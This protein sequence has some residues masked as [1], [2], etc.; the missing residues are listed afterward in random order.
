MTETLARLEGSPE[1]L[2]TRAPE[3]VLAE[4]QRAANALKNVISHKEKRVVINGEVY[5]EFE[6]WST[7]GSFYNVAAGAEDAIPVEIF[8]VKGA[9]ATAYVIRTDTGLR[10]SSAVAYC[11]ED[12]E[13]WQD[14]PWFQLA[15]MAQ[16]RAGAKALRFVLSK[17]V[18]LAGY[19]PTPAEEMEGVK[20]KKAVVF[21]F[22]KHKDQEPASLELKDLHSELAFW[23]KKVA[24]ETNPRY[25]ANNEKLVAAIQEAI[26]EKTAKIESPAREAAGIPPQ[27]AEVGD[28]PV[29]PAGDVPDEKEAAI[30]RINEHIT[31]GSITKGKIVKFMQTNWREGDFERLKELPLLNLQTILAWISTQKGQG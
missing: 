24:E 6:D 21:P 29:T 1:L 3:V 4:A 25:K 11:M 14:K 28:S 8:G 22:G 15:S 2:M 31:A 27:G 16:T 7:A 19:K 13:N 20:A 12:E 18:V 10:I 26:A 23:Q 9:K 17:I 5:L 30:I